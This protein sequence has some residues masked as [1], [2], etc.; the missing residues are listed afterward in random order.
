MQKLN[1]KIK[2]VLKTFHNY[3]TPSLNFKFYLKTAI[4]VY[5]TIKFNTN[6]ITI[7][8]RTVKTNLKYFIS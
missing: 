1:K 6:V 5:I 8:N 3:L 7:S 2:T 4:D